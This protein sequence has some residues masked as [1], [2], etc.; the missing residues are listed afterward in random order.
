[1]ASRP[2]LRDLLARARLGHGLKR[3]RSLRRQLQPRRGSS[4]RSQR[5]LPLAGGEDFELLVAVAPRAYAHLSARF[6]ARFRRPL[7]RVGTL[8]AD[9]GLV[10][11][12]QGV[13]EPL[14]R[15]GWD[16]FS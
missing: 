5:R 1:M 11:V 16:H 10:V 8:Q 9:E 4:A 2:T 14:A 12:K 3:C 7:L 15:S 6:A 13:T